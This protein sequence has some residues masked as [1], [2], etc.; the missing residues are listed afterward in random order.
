MVKNFIIKNGK[1]NSSPFA[2]LFFF[3]FYLFL[4]SNNPQAQPDVVL[5]VMVSMMIIGI[6]PMLIDGIM[7]FRW[8][9]SYAVFLDMDKQE[10]ILNHSLFFRKKRISLKDIKEIDTL[11]GYIILFSSTPLSK[12]QKMVSKT[13]NSD[14]YTIRFLRIETSERRELIRILSALNS[15]QE[16]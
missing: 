3:F 10:I 15:K 7:F 11:N 14:D 5:I 6:I 13:R 16:E 12:W 4:L 9:I 2:V 8:F 1:K